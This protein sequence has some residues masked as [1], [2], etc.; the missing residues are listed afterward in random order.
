MLIHFRLL[1]TDLDPQFHSNGDSLRAFS[2]RVLPILRERDGRIRRVEI[3][4]GASPEGPSDLNYTLSVNRAEAIRRYM[5]DKGL[6]PDS[7]VHIKCVGADWEGL[8]RMVAAGDMPYRREVLNII[9]NVPIWVVRGGKVVDGRKRQL[10]RLDRGKV[11]NYIVK[12]YCPVL[13]TALSVMVVWEPDEN[14]DGASRLSSKMANLPALL[15]LTLP[16]DTAGFTYDFTLPTLTTPHRS[17]LFASLHNNLL[18]D[19]VAVPNLGAELYLGRGWSAV[20]NWNYAWWRDDSRARYWRTYGGDLGLRYWFGDA[21]ESKPLTGHHLGAYFGMFTY[22]FA[23]GDEGYLGGKP[24]GTLWDR[25]H[26]IA[27][28]DYGYSLPIGRR[29]NLDFTFGA[30]YMWG[31]TQVYTPAEGVEGIYIWDHT[32]T[33]RYFGPTKAEISLVW[34]IGN[35]NFNQLRPKGGDQ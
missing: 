4:G 10:M 16:A 15:P 33:R 14:P 18:F 23:W 2:D 5:H 1:K 9:D 20:V 7:V 12:H 22:D 27:G 19:V 26:R 17:P 6:L 30:G 3:R 28:I 29:L 24:G 35:S 32:K 34:L 31:E 25:S 21:A 11:W 13:R 8:R